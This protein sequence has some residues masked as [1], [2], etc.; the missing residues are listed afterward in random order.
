MR[1]ETCSAGDY[2]IG[3]V[4]VERS[5][6]KRTEKRCSCWD[7]KWGNEVDQSPQLAEGLWSSL[8]LC[9][10]SIVGFISI[11]LGFIGFINSLGFMSGQP[12]QG[13]GSQASSD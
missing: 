5:R 2:G 8:V 1:S 4:E 12:D 3:C 9:R 11:F 10:T 7:S 13:Q 6:E